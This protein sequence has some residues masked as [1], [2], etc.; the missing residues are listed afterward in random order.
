MRIGETISSI[1]KIAVVVACVYAFLKWQFTEPQLDEIGQF[2]EKAC[3]DQMIGR[4]NAKAA[5]VY[6]V[7]KNESGYV[8]RASLTFANGTPARV[9]CLANNQGGVKELILEQ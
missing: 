1:V 8:V 7:K 5:K 3:V 4:Y 6:S 2:A 9:Y